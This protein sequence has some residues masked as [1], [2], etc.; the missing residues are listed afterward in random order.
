MCVL[1]SETLHVQ[2]EEVYPLVFIPRR[3]EHCL[4][5]TRSNDVVKLYVRSIN[6][7]WVNY[8]SIHAIG[9]VCL[10]Y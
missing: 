4:R 1:S 6:V 9:N 2:L 5:N 8:A 10:Y 7:G 3:P